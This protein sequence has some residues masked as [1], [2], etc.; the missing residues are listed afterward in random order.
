MAY[1]YQAKELV[2]VCFHKHFNIN[3]DKTRKYLLSLNE[4]DQNA[5][6]QK[7]TERLYKKIMSKTYDVDYGIIPKS[8]GDITNL[9]YYDEMMDTLDILEGIITKNRMS[10]EYIDSVKT[11]IKNVEKRK[12][13]FT[14]GYR[15]K[16]EFVV[17]LYQN[18]CLSITASISYL[19]SSCV[20]FINTPG[21]DNYDVVIDN[22]RYNRS[23]DFMILKNIQEFNKSCDNQLDPILDTVL[24]NTGK[25]FSGS[26]SV[27]KGMVIIAAAA[28]AL[29]PL[30]RDLTYFFYLSRVKIA[31]YLE[32]QANF[33]K[34]NAYR[35]QANQGSTNKEDEEKDRRISEKQ[36]KISE[37]LMNISNKINI[38]SPS[39]VKNVERE[40]G[41]NKDVD[42]TIDEIDPDGSVLF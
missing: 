35:I 37:K 29:L 3:D 7:L 16:S 31:D 33:I 38:D 39:T 2:N 12:R 4:A 40:I 14:L 17:M 27:I 1:S 6:L 10:S 8:Q 25:G 9:E 22:S 11:A 23:K 36:L 21:T 18:I 32:V 42:L 13:Q 30:L 19:I 15:A 41:K 28:L 5:V 34:L 20:E 24:K 26:L